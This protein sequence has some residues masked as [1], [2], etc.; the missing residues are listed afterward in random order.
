MTSWY[1]AFSSMKGREHDLH[2]ME[3]KFLTA[4][5]GKEVAES[6]LADA[7]KGAPPEPQNSLRKRA[8]QLAND[9]DQFWNERNDS[10]PPRS[11]GHADATG[12]QGEINKKSDVY[13]A[14]T[15][16]LCVQRFGTKIMGI[17]KEMNAKGLP[18]RYLHMFDVNNNLRCLYGGDFPQSETQMLRDLAY[19][20]DAY[21]N[22]VEF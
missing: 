13:D 8:T 1:N 12:E 10:H 18:T 6:R 15:N 2:A 9:I 16:R 17:P 22:A 11:N 19:R 20:L 21:D 4:E 5:R 14:E 3:G 7:A